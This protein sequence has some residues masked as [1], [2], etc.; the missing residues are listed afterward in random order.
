MGEPL[1]LAAVNV[2]VSAAHE[3]GAEASGV[4]ELEQAVSPRQLMLE[5]PTRLLCGGLGRRLVRLLGLD[6][7]R[8]RLLCLPWARL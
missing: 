7:S 6:L 4:E 1:R 3:F 8:R 2:Q 5:L